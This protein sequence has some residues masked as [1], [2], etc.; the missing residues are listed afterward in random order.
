MVVFSVYPASGGKVAFVISNSTV[1]GGTDTANIFYTF[2]S[3]SPCSALIPANAEIYV[4]A[5]SVATPGSGAL[6]WVGRAGVPLFVGAPQNWRACSF[7]HLATLTGAA[8]TLNTYIASWDQFTQTTDDRVSFI[9]AAAS[10][11][12]AAHINFAATANPYVPTAYTLAAGTTQ[13]GIMGDTM[14]VSYVVTGVGCTWDV[15]L[16]AVCH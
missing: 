3:P 4:D 6:N 11:R 16:I 5:R 15:A 13:Q 14:R 9:Q 12:Q 8:G 7:Y 2:G 1:A 10:G